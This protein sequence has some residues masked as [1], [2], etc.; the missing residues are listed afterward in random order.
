MGRIVV[1]GSLNMDLV[2]NVPK[3]P[4]PGATVVGDRLQMFAGGKGANQ[5]V[6]A[7][8]LGSEVSLIGRVGQDAMGDRLLEEL[9]A[10][11]VDASGIGRD[12]EL[13]TGAGLIMVETGGQNQIAVA[14]GANYSVGRSELATLV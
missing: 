2:V 11:G 14:P 8:R 3:L 12:P 7:A 10:A 9:K 6:A 4:Q 1:F 13:P 5:A